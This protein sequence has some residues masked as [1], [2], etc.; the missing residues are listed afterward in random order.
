MDGAAWMA[1][2]IYWRWPEKKIEGV[3]NYNDIIVGTGFSGLDMALILPEAG[4]PY[5][6]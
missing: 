3:G 2:N 5:S 4:I 1:Y 6:W